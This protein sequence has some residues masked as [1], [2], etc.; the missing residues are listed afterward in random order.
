MKLRLNVLMVAVED[1]SIF[2]AKRKHRNEYHVEAGLMVKEEG[3]AVHSTQIF[4]LELASH[5][6]SIGLTVGT[7]CPVYLF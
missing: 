2:S 1:A 5:S 6:G 7:F 3:A 4:A